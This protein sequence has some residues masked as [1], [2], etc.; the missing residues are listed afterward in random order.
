MKKILFCCLFL[1]FQFTMGQDLSSEKIDLT[2]QEKPVLQVLLDIESKT[3]YKFYFLEEWLEDYKVSGQFRDADLEEILSY[4]ADG[5][6]EWIA[7]I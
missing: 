1:F 5:Q 4:R 2:F 3:S 7:G 6:R